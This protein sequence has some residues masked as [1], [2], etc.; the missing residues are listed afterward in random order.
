MKKLRRKSEARKGIKY[1][2]IPLCI[3]LKFSRINNVYLQTIKIKSSEWLE[4]CERGG[5]N[6]TMR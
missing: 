1:D 4:P 6:L 5:G 3:Y 2:H